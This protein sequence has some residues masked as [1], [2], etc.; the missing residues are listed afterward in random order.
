[1]SNKRDGI[2]KYNELAIQN[3]KSSKYGERFTHTR[4]YRYRIDLPITT[5]GGS[6]SS[7]YGYVMVVMV[8]FS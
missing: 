3:K 6:S 7:R 5:G 4:E 8:L 2:H 1:M